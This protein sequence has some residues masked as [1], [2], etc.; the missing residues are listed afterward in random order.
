MS[1]RQ[2][3]ATLSVSTAALAAGMLLPPQ[4]ASA[5]V[6]STV[7]NVLDHGAVGDGVTNDS[8]SVAAAVAALPAN[9]G[10]LYFPAGRYVL[11]QPVTLANKDVTVRGD[12]MQLSQLFF[13]ASSGI[14]YSTTNQFNDALQVED[15]CLVTVSDNLYVGI[16]ATYPNN[17]GS[18]WK[19][20]IIERVMLSGTTSIG[21]YNNGG[22]NCNS[23]PQNWQAGI[24]L[25]NSAVSHVR[26]CVV[27]GSG[28]H[29][30]LLKGYT[31]DIL[32]HGCK[33]YGA[34]EAIYKV[35]PSEGIIIDNCMGIN[36]GT[37]VYLN[38]NATSNAG[39]YASIQ[40]CH[41]NYFNNGIIINYHPQMFMSNCLFY[42]NGTLNGG[43]DVLLNGCERSHITNS[44]F[45]VRAST[46]YG[47]GI[48]VQ[49][50]SSVLIQG[51]I[52]QERETAVWLQASSSDCMVQNNRISGNASNILNLGTNNLIGQNL[53]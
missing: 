36:V 31:V 21:E 13:P 52:I 46:G 20:T 50:S 1:R 43:F 37:F 25:E 49:N 44:T 17:V 15:L 42:K 38:P 8:P 16:K 26:D 9:G 23:G 6:P 27:R 22:N 35:G 47:N 34:S 24:E 2:A 29:G 28:G 10:V 18:P 3:L 32:I 45:I 53:H 11:N 41:A 51:N 14:V 33:F 12:G 30:I 7:I 5:T 39:V 48:V 4:T 19:N 40:N